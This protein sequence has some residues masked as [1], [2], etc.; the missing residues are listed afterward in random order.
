MVQFET[1]Q[2]YFRTI[3]DE[4]YIFSIVNFSD[5]FT[6]T[7]WG[8]KQIDSSEHARQSS[9]VREFLLADLHKLLPGNNFTIGKSPHGWPIV[10]K[11]DEEMPLPIS[12]AHHDRYVAYSFQLK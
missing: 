3:I 5:D 9:E 11:D 8:V 6:S 12:L 2:L 7:H 1:F 4:G 10:I